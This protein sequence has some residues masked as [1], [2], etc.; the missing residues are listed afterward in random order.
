MAEKVLDLIKSSLWNN[1]SNEEITHNTYDE[2]QKHNLFLLPTSILPYL[3]MPDNLRIEWKKH[4]LQYLIFQEQYKLIQNSLPISVPYTVLKGTSAAQYYP[5][6]EYRVM[7]DID[8]MTDRNDFH[9]AYLDLLN[10]GY[11]EINNANREITLAKD[12]I[13]IELHRFFASLNDPKQSQYLDDLIIANI[14]PSHVLPDMVNGLVLLEHISQHLEHG[15][16]LRQIIDW[17][18]FV[19][20][21]LPDGKWPEFKIMAKSI[22]LKKLAVIVTR[23]CELYL[24]L[25][26]RTWSKEADVTLC[27]NL[28]DYILSSGDFGRKWTSDSHVGQTIF[29]YVRGP[30]ATFKWLQERG[31]INW[32]AARKYA[33]LRPFAWIYQA[34]RY[35]SKGLRQEG[36]SGALRLEYEAARKRLRLFDALNV[37]QK[38]K[39]LIIYK[40]GK[41]VKK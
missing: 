32:Q 20:Q 7:G 19:Y 35:I 27:N 16:G 38:A 28:M 34:G 39:G 13:I 21:C 37:K 29:T 5:Y 18:M 6:P 4:I 2:M 36:S 40:D 26:E 22:G 3:S 9:Q 12:G 1:E 41:Y 31:M 11:K 10:N 25:P 30:V 15:L 14:N 17:M 33:F 23:M 24:G 8:I